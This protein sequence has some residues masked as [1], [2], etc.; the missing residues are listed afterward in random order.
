MGSVPVS[1]RVSCVC[2]SC[3]DSTSINVTK[4]MTGSISFFRKGGSSAP[5]FTRPAAKL[6]T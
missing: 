5:K 4:M 2:V 1:E 3:V 6:K